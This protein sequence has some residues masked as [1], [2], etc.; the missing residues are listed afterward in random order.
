MEDNDKTAIHEVMEQ[1]TISI[2]KAGIVTTLNARASVLAA[3]N[4]VFGRYNTALSPNQNMNLSAALLSRFD[5]VF[6]LLDMPDMDVDTKLAQHVTQVHMTERAPEQETA[7]LLTEHEMRVYI[8]RAV[9]QRPVVP[10]EVGEQISELYVNIRREEAREP[11]NYGYT[12]ARTLVSI[13]RM[14]QALARLRFADSVTRGDVDEAVRLMSV[15]KQSLNNSRLQR[16]T[17]R[18][19]VDRIFELIKQMVQAESGPAHDEADEDYTPGEVGMAE[20][21]QRVAAKGMTSRDLE[22]MLREYEQLG[23][24]FVSPDRSR[25]RFVDHHNK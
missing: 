24:L 5:I 21:E 1:Q 16:R 2:S 20:L 23:I 19:P 22:D 14:A 4:P 10:R 18:S 3:A 7:V 9:Q 13:I 6:L 25:V 11:S 8:S 15:S 17:R 12:T